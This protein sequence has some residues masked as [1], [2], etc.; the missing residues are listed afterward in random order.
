[1]PSRQASE[2]ELLGGRVVDQGGSMA[3]RR[4]RLRRRACLAIFWGLGVFWTVQIGLGFAVE[5]I[6][7]DIRDQEFAAKLHRL[8]ALIRAAPDR[9][10]VVMLG[11]SRTLMALDAR[12]VDLTIDGRRPIV[13]NFGIRGGGPTLQ[14]ICLRRMLAQGIKPDVLLVEVLL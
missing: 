11:S 6:L 2:L 14:L 10:L 3:N 9:P 5:H 13:F 8:Q 1:R 12:R 4:A 7:P